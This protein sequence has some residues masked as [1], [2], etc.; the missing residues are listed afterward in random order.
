MCRIKLYNKKHREEKSLNILNFQP[1]CRNEGIKMGHTECKKN[2]EDKIC[3]TDHFT[4]HQF[5]IESKTNPFWIAF[6]ISGIYFVLGCLWILLSDRFVE[7]TVNDQHM[8]AFISLIKGWLYVLLTGWLVFSLV[9]SA[10]KKQKQIENELIKSVSELNK[11]NEILDATQDELKRNYD[12]LKEYQEKL[13]NFAYTD[14]LTGLPN[15]RALYENLSNSVKKFPEER[16]ALI[17]VDLDNFKY[18]ND[19][20]G[21]AYGDKFIIETG[22]KLSAL[23]DNGH[24]AYRLGGDEF[25][26]SY[27]GFYSFEQVRECADVII[28]SFLKPFEIEG[29]VIYTTVSIGISTYPEDGSDVDSLMRNADIAMYKA[30]TLG[31]NQ[32]VVYDTEM[33][34]TVKDRMQ[35]ERLL[36]GAFKNEEFVVYYQS[37]KDLNTGKISGFEALLRWNSPE[38][39]FVLPLKFIGI[40]EET[41]MI[42]FIGEWVLRKACLFIKQLHE[43]GHPDLMIAVNISMIQ[44][45]HEN[46]I[47]SVLK[48]L[49]D[50]D[51]QPEYLE[52][53]ITESILMESYQ[54]IRD[55]LLLLR[56]LGVKIALDDFGKGYSSL[57]YLSQLPIDTLKIDKTFIDGINSEKE[58]QALASAIIDIGSNLELSIVAEG[59][60]KQDQI[61]FLKK[62][63]CHKVQGY[64]IS[65]PMPSEDVISLLRGNNNESNNQ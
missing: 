59:V 30:K 14:I 51:L 52:L 5:D 16:K 15:R 18:I 27:C 21:H 26:I 6:R 39:G 4:E 24:A 50:T 37:Q 8:I 64:F 28:Q 46:F 61:D 23:L 48:I 17:F 56:E 25:I 12:E 32:Y 35:I 13:H 22:K 41:R 20:M 60:E 31:K 42:I 38:L 53:E 1:F 65:R 7:I 33:H 36:R 19:T 45:L 44:L 54:T 40:A 10:L 11:K 62:H 29:S 2:A 58:S 9:H 43:M 55:K 34:E 63:K 49:G 3:F 47:D 57:S